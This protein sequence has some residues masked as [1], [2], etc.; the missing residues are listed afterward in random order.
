VAQVG[1]DGQSSVGCLDVDAA[2]ALYLTGSTNSNSF[3][4]VNAAD[5]ANLAGS[6]TPFV[7]KVAPDGQSLVFSTY[8]G[9]TGLDLYGDI[10]AGPRG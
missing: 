7:T 5:S 8:F 3:P 10:A 1:L 9:G 4:T 2:G 6:F